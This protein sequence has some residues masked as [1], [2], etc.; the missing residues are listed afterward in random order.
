MFAVDLRYYYFFYGA[1]AFALALAATPLAAWLARRVGAVDSAGGRRLHLGAVPRLGGVGIAM[2]VGAP[3]AFLL[4]RSGTDLV[5]ERLFAILA[6]TA[7]VLAVGVAD[8]MRRVPVGAKL[9]VEVGAA[10]L[11]WVMGVRIEALT[12]PFG[13]GT[14][15]PGLW[16]MP[17]TVLW[18]VVVTNAVNLI[19]GLDGLA[20][21]TGAMIAATLFVIGGDRDPHLRVAMV[22][23]AGALV[24]FLRHNLPPATVFMGDSGSLSVGFMLGALSV[25]SYAKAAAMAGVL[26]PVL[27]FGLPLSDMAYAVARRFW[28]GQS[29]S[30]PD[31][32][33]IHH[34]LVTL[35]HSPRTALAVLYGVNAALMALT[36]LFVAANVRADLV[37]ALLVAAGLLAGVRLFG[38]AETLRVGVDHARHLFRM[39]RERHLHFLLRRLEAQAARAAGAEDLAEGVRTFLREAGMLGLA[40]EGAKG[41]VVRITAVEGQ[42]AS[43]GGGAIELTAPVA[44]PAGAVTS[45]R[46]AWDAGRPIAVRA[47]LAARVAAAVA[48]SYLERLRQ[49][50]DGQPGS[51]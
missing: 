15:H 3:L 20:A 9:A 29:L 33:H 34:K 14:W 11:L 1:V 40:L 6:C 16:G 10:C 48:E 36:L 47:D 27:A 38:Y 25:V 17:L 46:V 4:T 12:N 2:A 7:L 21:G 8:D 44:D 22:V 42:D 41:T 49:L 39:R 37:V 24:G 43:G 28:R 32:E 13:G 51:P 31:G 35:G 23:L 30:R 19:D 45:V 26:L 18:L 50:G 5:H